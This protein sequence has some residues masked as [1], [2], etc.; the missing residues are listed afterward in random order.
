MNT[1]RIILA[2]LATLA[3]TTAV[4]EPLPGAARDQ[5]GRCT[6]AVRDAVV[7]DGTVRIHHTITDI[8]TV[9]ARRAFVI[10]TA[11]FERG[12][13]AARPFVARCLADRW[14]DGVELR[15][16]RPAGA[17]AAAVPVYAAGGS[18]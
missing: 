8:R 15:W 7:A 18:R 12:E 13:A 4:A 6:A 14:G 9:G 1:R 16:L 2:I 17:P 10:E 11:V 5:A 3:A